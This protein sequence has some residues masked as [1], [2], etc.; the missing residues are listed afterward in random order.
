MARTRTN[1]RAA[2]YCRISK[3][4]DDT[5]LGVERQEKDCRKLCAERGWIVVDVYCDNDISATDPKKKR[6]E[7]DRL[8]KDIANARVDAV[9]VYAEDRLHRRPAELETFVAACDAAGLTKLAS[10][11]GDV[12]LNDP[13]ALMMLRMKGAMAAREV[14][15]LQRRIK[16]KLRDKAERGEF[17]G[18][19]RPFGYQ[20]NGIDIRKRE[21]ALIRQAAQKV[22]E[23]SSLRAIATDW[24]KRGI[25]TSWDNPINETGL[26]KMLTSPRIAGFSQYQGDIIGKAAWDAILDEATWSQVCTI[27]KDPARRGPRPSRVYPLRGV[28]K[29]GKCGH[30][31]A[32]NPS[33]TGARRYACKTNRGGCGKLTLTADHVEGYVFDLI[34]PLADMTDVRDALQAENVG[35]AEA[36]QEL[37]LANANDACML[38]ERDEMFA[39]GEMSRESYVKQTRI[40]RQRIEARELRIQV[41]HGGTALSHFGGEV[42]AGWDE[43]S[44]DDKRS[45]ILSILEYI[46]VGP[47]VKFGSNKFDADRLTFKFRNVI[48]IENVNVAITSLRVRMT[49]SKMKWETKHPAENVAFEESW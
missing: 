2:I 26:R 28:L 48:D 8:L 33:N 24:N 31:L 49:H 18:G 22:L 21:A 45:I 36:L 23:G 29:C 6:P 25:R 27:L 9:A 42:R 15:V 40:I 5:R 43:M 19:R 11:S 39:D 47:V 1:V 32:A 16:R 37:V 7:Y 20:E 30:W 38:A 17:H 46:E 3:D 12:N 41:L 13:D 44:A 34:V 14:A 10:V 35:T 4:S